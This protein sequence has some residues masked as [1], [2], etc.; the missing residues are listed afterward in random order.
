MCPRDL[1]NCFLVKNGRVGSLVSSFLAKFKPSLLGATAHWVGLRMRSSI[2][3]PF[4]FC[5]VTAHF[6]FGELQLLVES[7]AGLLN[8]LKAKR[9]SSKECLKNKTSFSVDSLTSHKVHKRATPSPLWAIRPFC[10][11][12]RRKVLEKRL[13]TNLHGESNF[14]WSFE[15]AFCVCLWKKECVVNVTPSPFRPLQKSFVS[16]LD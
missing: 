4:L 1:A 12:R 5:G 14:S 10:L 16:L 2:S 9:S 7:A 15:S 11:W 3:S 8:R 6:S 13:T